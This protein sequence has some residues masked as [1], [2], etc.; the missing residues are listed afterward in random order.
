MDTFKER[1]DYGE[2]PWLRTLLLLSQWVLPWASLGAR[3]G[4]RFIAGRAQLKPAHC[5]GPSRRKGPAD[6]RTVYPLCTLS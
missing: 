1:R 5:F 2:I 4:L 3:Q 6:A